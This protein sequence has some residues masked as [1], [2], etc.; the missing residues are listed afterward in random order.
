MKIKTLAA[1]LLSLSALHAHATVIDFNQVIGFQT[2]PSPYQEDGFTITN[3]STNSSAML[4]WGTLS[5][6]ADPNGNTYSHN[7]GSTTSTLT[8]TGGGSLGRICSSSPLTTPAWAM[9]TGSSAIPAP[10]S[11]NFRIMLMLFSPSAPRTTTLCSPLGPPKRQ[12]APR[13]AEPMCRQRCSESAAG[14]WGRPKRS[15]YAGAA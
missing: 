14:S 3:S 7:Y 6:N 15:R 10:C 13:W 1:A 4:F 11:A 8:K 12:R 9:W 5:Y 2:L